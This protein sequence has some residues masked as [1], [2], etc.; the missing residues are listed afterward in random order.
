MPPSKHESGPAAVL[1]V[2]SC[3]TPSVSF[4][5]K[6]FQKAYGADR[7]DLI[8]AAD[9]GELGDDNGEEGRELLYL[10]KKVLGDDA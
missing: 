1:V 6:Q 2:L 9:N 8:A 7:T 3:S 10:F 5:K 4:V